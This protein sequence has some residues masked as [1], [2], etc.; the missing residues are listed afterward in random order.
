MMDDGTEVRKQ[1]KA[2]LPFFLAEHV[3]PDPAYSPSNQS[4]RRKLSGTR[5][6]RRGESWLAVAMAIMFTLVSFVTCKDDSHIMAS[7]ARG[8]KII[9][10]TTHSDEALWVKITEAHLSKDSPCITQDCYAVCVTLPTAVRDSFVPPLRCVS[11][12]SRPPGLGGHPGLRDNAR[13][14]R[15]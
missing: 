11:A 4:G 3:Q 7:V 6:S 5:K 2:R 8:D 15:R 1:R 10:G 12:W 14:S 13:P 9:A